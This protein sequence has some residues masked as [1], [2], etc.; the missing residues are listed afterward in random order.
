MSYKK[1]YK[2]CDPLYDYIYLDSG[3]KALI[4]QPLFQRLRSIQ[5]LGF[6][7][8]AFPSGTGNRF[9]HCLGAFHLAGLAF[10]SIFDKNQSL[11]LRDSKKQ[12]FRKALKISALLHDIGHG[13]LS[14]SSESLMPDLKTLNLSSY[15]KIDFKRPARHEDYT[16]KCIMEEEGL[17]QA[18]QNTGI[19]PSVV[20]QILHEDFSGAEDFF[21][22]GGVDF[23]PLFKQIISSD[24]DVDRMDYLQRDS[25]LCGVKYGLLD[26][27][28]LLSHF[29]L[30]IKNNQAFLSVEREA[31]YTLES[32][33]MGR[34]HMR[35]AVYFH[36]K[37]AVY[38]E[39]LKRYALQS[40]WRLPQN[41]T[42]YITWTDSK[43]FDHLKA[44]QKNP[45][46]KRI[47]GN[48]P[49]LRLYEYI[50]FESSKA[51]Q[52][53]EE[54]SSR[55]QN[56]LMEND[57]GFMNINSK[58]N[59]IKTSKLTLKKFPIYLKNQ[60]LN[61]VKPLDKSPALRPFPQRKIQRIYV[62]PE[63]FSKAQSL[64]KK[65]KNSL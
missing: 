55:I 42:D 14:H 1:Q 57:L 47:V 7:E 21:K 10:D 17:F 32:F 54:Y 11:A 51:L 39:M 44:N 8:K 46:A 49:Y 12:Q 18:L 25:L 63:D 13:P 9:C 16:I 52:K 23:L 22:E 19:E 4:E 38:N 3:E 64:L 5:Q 56:I 37:S 60:V 20:A 35:L 61:Q 59:S 29:N 62:P 24:F 40:D 30:H 34:E 31:L 58:K 26:V 28:W 48:K 15:L 50:F 2:I 65:I 41:L 36:H 45:W 43:L 27:I 6:S 53:G 33:I